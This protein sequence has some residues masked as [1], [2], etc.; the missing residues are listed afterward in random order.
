MLLRLSIAYLPVFGWATHTHT[1]VRAPRTLVLSLSVIS[2]FRF[3]CLLP[4]RYK[5]TSLCASQHIQTKR[6][7]PNFDWRIFVVP[8]YNHDSD[9]IFKWINKFEYWRSVYAVSDSEVVYTQTDRNPSRSIQFLSD[10]NRVHEEMS[11]VENCRAEPGQTLRS[12]HNCRSLSACIRRQ[13]RTRHIQNKNKDRISR[14][15]I[16]G[17]V[18]SICSYTAI[19]HQLFL[20]STYLSAFT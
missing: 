7:S 14:F 11:L 20:K 2:I 17:E 13:R 6:L 16:V 3:V 18:C 15:R 4:D 8:A 5:G 1:F 9:N 19:W 12:C 10:K